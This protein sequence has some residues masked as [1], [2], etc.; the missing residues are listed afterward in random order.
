M[1]ANT[2]PTPRLPTLAEFPR[3]PATGA[4]LPI[5]YGVLH[6]MLR[7]PP[8]IDLTKPIYEQVRRT[9]AQ[10]TGP[11]AAAPIRRESGV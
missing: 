2:T 10:A 11:G 7:I 1:A 6:G 9:A 5:G 8:D 4:L 3:D